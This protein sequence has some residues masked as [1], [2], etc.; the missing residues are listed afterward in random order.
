MRLAPDDRCDT[1][2][3]EEPTER[4]LRVGA[5]AAPERIRGMRLYGAQMLRCWGL[6]PEGVD[7]VE[8]LISELVTN[9]V[10]HGGDEVVLDIAYTPAGVVRVEVF[11]GSPAPARLCSAGPD[12]EHGRGL[13][14]VAA[15]SDRWGTAGGGTRTWCTVTV[16][17][18]STA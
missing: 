13:A 2:A 17:A 3:P 12:D 6:H 15:L 18:A 11:D 4:W 5:T 1:P 16:P 10:Q 9:G 8:L 14:L 7:T